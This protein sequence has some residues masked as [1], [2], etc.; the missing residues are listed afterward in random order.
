MRL[1]DHFSKM[2][3]DGKRGKPSDWH[4]SPQGYREA[5]QRF[6][7]QRIELG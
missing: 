6:A 2:I 7:L 1:S 5:D 3:N 4:R